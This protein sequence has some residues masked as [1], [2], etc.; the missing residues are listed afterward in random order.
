M[1]K[2]KKF[3]GLHL[4]ADYSP[5]GLVQAWCSEVSSATDHDPSP[6]HSGHGDQVCKVSGKNSGGGWGA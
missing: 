2:K 6:L 3:T 5:A 1:Q 4:G